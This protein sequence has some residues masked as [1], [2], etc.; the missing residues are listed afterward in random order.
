MTRLSAIR[1][2]LSLAWLALSGCT[3]LECRIQPQ[4]RCV[5]QPSGEVRCWRWCVDSFD[6]E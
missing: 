2:A 4:R 1:L 3:H 6:E 5:V